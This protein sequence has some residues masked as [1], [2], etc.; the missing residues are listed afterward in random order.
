M[1]GEDSHLE[2]AYED[3]FISD[4]DEE[5]EPEEE[6]DDPELSFTAWQKD[7]DFYRKEGSEK[8]II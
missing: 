1:T 3:R 2:E 4:M 8:T 7:Q 6:I 5:E